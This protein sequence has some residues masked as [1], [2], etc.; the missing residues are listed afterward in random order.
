MI[1]KILIE[2]ILALVTFFAGSLFWQLCKRARFLGAVIGNEPFLTQFISRSAL[3]NASPMIT[4][5]AEKKLTYAL[6]VQLVID[7]DIASQ[8]RTTIMFLVVILAALA[9]SWLLGPVYFVVSL[10]LFFFSAASPIFESTRSN[11]LQHVLALALILHR[12]HQE[13]PLECDE[14]IQ[15]VPS[16]RPVYNAV[17][18]VS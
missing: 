5:F 6:N 3:E 12:W 11:A 13:N 9:G 8:R 10:V 4:P 16:L 18:I 7:A 17:R 14:W 1:A 15:R 2:I